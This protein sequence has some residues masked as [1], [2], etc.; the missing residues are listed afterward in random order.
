M[1]PARKSIR[2]ENHL[3]MP[4]IYRF[5]LSLVNLMFEKLSSAASF[6]LNAINLML[7]KKSLTCLAE[8]VQKATEILLEYSRLGKNPQ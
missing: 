6:V 3:I 1:Q 5:T 8:L 4:L 2:L 7:K